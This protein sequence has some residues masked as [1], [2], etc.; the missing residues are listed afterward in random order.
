MLE[1]S[2]DSQYGIGDSMWDNTGLRGFDAGL[3][4]K[5]T[6]GWHP[7]GNG[8][9]LFGFSCLAGGNRYPDGSFDGIGDYGVW[10][11]A[12]EFDPNNAWYRNLGYGKSGVDLYL[13]GKTI[14]FG[15]R[16]LRD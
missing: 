3:N 15:V 7:G 16:C 12:S 11:S 10:W 1:G 13:Y 6:S 14:G 5:S 9:D 8:T 4:L 2:V